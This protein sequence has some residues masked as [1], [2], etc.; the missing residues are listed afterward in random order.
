[1][2]NEYNTALSRHIISFDF[3]SA[4]ITNSSMKYRPKI[5]T[6]INFPENL[7][8]KYFMCHT[9]LRSTY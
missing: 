2:I 9:V 5:I 7:S 4:G 8:S 3:I 1:M 6:V